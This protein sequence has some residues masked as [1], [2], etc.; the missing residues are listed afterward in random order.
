ME[1]LIAVEEARALLRLA[2][3][4]SI[5]RWLAEK[6]RV[7]TVADKGTAALDELEKQVKAGWGESLRTAYAELADAASVEDDPFGAAE[8][9]FLQQQ[10][11]AIAE[12]TKALARRVKEADDVA[13]RARMTAEQT[14]DLAERRLSAVLAR[15]GADEALAAYELRYAAIA[16]A[17]A[18]LAASAGG[19]R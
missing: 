15:R 2:K 16:E 8:R 18:A 7:R 12:S 14:F 1:T 6:S 5:W 13:Y 9:E 19:A 17:Q 4:W 3:E 11:Q 10:A